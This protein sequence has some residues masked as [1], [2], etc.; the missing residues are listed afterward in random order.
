MSLRTLVS[1]RVAGGTRVVVDRNAE[2]WI[3]MTEDNAV[4]TGLRQR[5]RDT[6]GGA[7]AAEIQPGNDA[8]AVDRRF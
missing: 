4:I 7:G 8:L 5:L 3:L 6:A 1:K 2:G